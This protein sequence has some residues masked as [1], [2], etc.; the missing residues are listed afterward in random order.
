MR[1]CV[2][3]GRL[4][5]FSAK[6]LVAVAVLL[7]GASILAT[8][9]ATA[10]A[11]PR[12]GP[13]AGQAAPGQSDPRRPEIQ[14]DL[15]SDRDPV[16]SP[17]P[18][19]VAE[20]AGSNTSNTPAKAGEIQKGQN[21]VYTL[22]EN[23]DEVLLNCTVI[24]EKGHPVEG[25]TQAD[26]RVWEDSAPQR[27]SSFR[28]Q[29][30]PV[31]IGLLIDNSGS[32]HDKRTAINHAALE[33]MRESNRQDTAF[34][35]NFND[36][37]YLDQGFTKDLVSLDR[38]LSHFDSRGTTA[39]YD[40]IAASADELSKHATYSKQVLLVVSDGADNASHLTEQKTI[41]RVQDLGGPVVYSIGLLYDADQREYQRAHEAL[42]TMSDDTGGVAY[43]PRSL[44]E[45][46][47]IA[48]DVA[49]DI[50]NQY[51]I[52]Y[53]STNLSGKSGF[54]VVHVEAI[55]KKGMKL[56]VRTRRGYYAKPGGAPA[57]QTAQ[58]A[59]KP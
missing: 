35:V 31:S 43:F 27:V 28:H 57:G 41:Q 29:D 49:R 58:T 54:R 50:R 38:G 1:Y 9:Q 21:G 47:S 26:F 53:H 39:L 4:V 8:A 22:H 23:V 13:V 56:S 40:A 52:G 10:P 18:I 20:T 15:A 30:Q 55:G 45:V 59:P 25:L 36:H 11:A 32:M 46:N 37:A 33:L 14:P 44:E 24:D 19:P 6:N 17:D 16:P 48:S 7:C 42:Q 5:S 12:S 51:T 3:Y 34:V 2:S